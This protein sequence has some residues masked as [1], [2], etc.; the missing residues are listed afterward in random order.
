[1]VDLDGEN[2]TPGTL[3]RSTRRVLPFSEPTPTKKKK[4]AINGK[5]VLRQ[6]VDPPQ[7]NG[8]PVSNG[9]QVTKK[10]ETLKTKMSPLPNEKFPVKV[11]VDFHECDGCQK[12]FLSRT[13]VLKHKYYCPNKESESPV[14]GPSRS[15]TPLP[16]VKHLNNGKAKTKTK[17]SQVSDSTKIHSKQGRA[18]LKLQQQAN[19]ISNSPK[20]KLKVVLP[21]RS[22]GIPSTNSDVRKKKIKKVVPS[23]APVRPVKKTQVASKKVVGPTESTR[24]S[25]KVT[26][27]KEGK[28]PEEITPPGRPVRSS[29]KASMT[30]VM[31]D[32]VEAS[33]LEALSPEQ[34]VRVAEQKCPFCSKHYVYRSNFKKHLLEGC[35]TPD[36]EEPSVISTP[37]KK[38][39]LEAKRIDLKKST[40]K[41]NSGSDL[42]ASAKGKREKSETTLKKM[43]K[44]AEKKT[45]PT[46]KEKTSKKA[47]AIEKNSKNLP[48]S[49]EPNKNLPK[50]VET[51]EPGI[52]TKTTRKIAILS[53]APKKSGQKIKTAPVKKIEDSAT[54]EIQKRDEK[55]CEIEET[56]CTNEGEIV[57]EIREKKPMEV[58]T[59]AHMFEQKEKDEVI[60]KCQGSTCLIGPKEPSTFLGNLT[61][62]DESM[63][64]T[65]KGN[66]NRNA[67]YFDISE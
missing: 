22:N 26:P 41:L 15:P 19:V 54:F 46:D 56:K 61:T 24:K 63:E 32:Q 30:L 25:S 43:E 38:P 33:F 47:K 2:V 60:E 67:S 3:R 13:S 14:A 11:A 40:T 18:N 9:A 27:K 57:T 53:K 16:P 12:K 50:S 55:T 52:S 42:K 34:R 21:A 20:T 28:E 49:V 17:S 6:R 7:V 44:S 29:R 10:S 64:V 4:I 23:I 5:R 37:V 35:D 8:S 1:M 36:E 39:S 58:N 31:E 59:N 45:Y 65:V 62:N 51:E 48:K 66:C